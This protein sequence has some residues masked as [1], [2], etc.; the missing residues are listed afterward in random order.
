VLSLQL[1]VIPASLSLSVS[2]MGQ[3]VV[4]AMTMGT[5]TATVVPAMNPQGIP[6]DDSVAGP[7]ETDQERFDQIHIDYATPCYSTSI[8]ICETGVK[9]L[10]HMFQIK[11]GLGIPDN[12]F[13]FMDVH[14]DV[15]L[16]NEQHLLPK[17]A[18]EKSDVLLREY[19]SNEVMWA[20]RGYAGEAEARKRYDQL[21]EI[22]NTYPPMQDRP[23]YPMPAPGT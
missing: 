18:K 11:T 5:Y 4:T 20:C 6:G 21:A 14:N 16:S 8:T 22:R 9:S 23:G 15:A 1:T 3:K 19:E 12:P 2:I 7:T 10:P 17:E 13:Y